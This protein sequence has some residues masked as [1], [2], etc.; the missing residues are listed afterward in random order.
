MVERI[1][2]VRKEKYELVAKL[3]HGMAKEVFK[4]RGK[5]SGK[6]FAIVRLRTDNLYEEQKT[7]LR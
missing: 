7:E 6:F 5:Q 2:E 3:G 4:V 1:N